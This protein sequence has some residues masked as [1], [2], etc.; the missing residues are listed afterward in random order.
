MKIILEMFNYIFPFHSMPFER[1]RSRISYNCLKE[2]IGNKKR[3]NDKG[4]KVGD[5]FDNL[6]FPLNKN[7][8][9]LTTRPCYFLE[10]WINVSEKMVPFETTTMFENILISERH[11]CFRINPMYME[12]VQRISEV[13][14]WRKSL[15]RWFH[16]R[17]FHLIT[18]DTAAI[19]TV[20]LDR[21]LSIAPIDKWRDISRIGIG[22][23]FIATKLTSDFIVSRKEFLKVCG[24][25]KVNQVSKLDKFERNV[26]ITL[27]FHIFVDS[28]YVLENNISEIMLSHKIFKEI[29]ESKRQKI[30]RLAMSYFDDVF[31]SIRYLAYRSSEI[32]AACLWLAVIE[33]LSY[34]IS[35]LSIVKLV[36]TNTDRF[37]AIIKLLCC[38]SMVQKNFNCN[39]FDE[40]RLS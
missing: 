27:D 7:P 4:K 8:V 24:F 14:F 29:K 32:V 22:C 16:T 30:R 34:P 33:V 2:T 36:K 5:E 31:I 21:C 26:L 1:K 17:S 37:Y 11:N 19:A 20:L 40:I 13:D 6:Y 9:I 38:S 3:N 35:L 12:Q 23:L 28:I 39:D 15:I 18:K 25:K 10:E